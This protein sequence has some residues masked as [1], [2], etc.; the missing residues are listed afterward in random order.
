MLLEHG[1]QAEIGE[2]ARKSYETHFN[3]S[4][5]LLAVS[6]TKSDMAWRDAERLLSF[7]EINGTCLGYGTSSVA[8][9]GCTRWGLSGS[10]VG[11]RAF[12]GRCSSP[13]SPWSPADVNLDR[14][15]A[16]DTWNP[17]TPRS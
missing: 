2:G 7:P 13:A 14:A 15:G 10:V 6:R 4:I 11:C 9:S 16:R 12:A 17:P 3:R 8:G 1:S 5:K